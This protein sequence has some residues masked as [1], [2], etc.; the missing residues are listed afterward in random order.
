MKR[1]TGKLIEGIKRTNA[2]ES[3]RFALT[4]RINF[5]PGQ[6][7]KVLFDEAD[8]NNKELNKYLSFS[9][10]P[11][12]DYLEVTKKLSHSTFSNKLASLSVGDEVG[13]TGPL[14][15]CVL[16]EEHK[17]ICFLIGGIGITPVISILEYIV[18]KKLPVDVTLFYSNKTEEDIAFR[19]ELDYWHATN[20]N[21]E[22]FYTITECQP[23]ESHCIGGRINKDLILQ[24]VDDVRKRI[25]F[26]F[27]PPRMTEAMKALCI[28]MGCK[29][30]N[31]KAESFIGY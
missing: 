25:F 8:P 3:F 1:I 5:I 17:K 22:V 16:K 15:N 7:L 30:E 19:K 26:I 20:N 9:S 31:I 27:G 29:K 6:F 4:E 2:V 23:K 11:A 13:F 28:E 21:I 24:K 10:S 18:D 12:K 14:G